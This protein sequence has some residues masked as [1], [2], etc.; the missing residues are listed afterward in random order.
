MPERAAR[1]NSAG[2]YARVMLVTS[3]LLSRNGFRHAFFTRQGGVS[4]GV[5]ATLNFAVSTGDEPGRVRQNVAL[6]AAAL[7][8]PA[9]R[10][11]FLSQVHGTGVVALSGEEDREAVVHVEGDATLTLRPGIACGVRSA[12][13]GTILVGDLRSGAVAAIHA[14]WRGTE[15]GVVEAAIDALTRATSGAVELVAAVG[16]LIEA[17]C[18]E[19]GHDVADRLAAC[20]ALGEAAVTRRPEK[21]HVDLRAI[22]GEK[23]RAKGIAAGAID[24][25]RGCTV[26]DAQRFFS[27]RRDGKASGRLLS[28]IVAGRLRVHASDLKQEDRKTGR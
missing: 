9:A 19:V 1:E 5:Y 20:S 4:E 3:P 14:G 15:A 23:L 26:C 12:D 28:A 27:F 6:A 18:F 8:V 7:G 21:A 2:A 13:C 17:C 11:Y 25:V 16:P 24:H 10:L 22:L